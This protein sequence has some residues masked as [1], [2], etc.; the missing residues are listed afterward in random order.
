MEELT[1][2]REWSFLLKPSKMFWWL[3]VRLTFFLVTVTCKYSIKMRKIVPQKSKQEKK[4]QTGEQNPNRRKSAWG[5]SAGKKCKKTKTRQGEMT[6][7]E[8]VQSHKFNRPY[9]YSWY[10]N[11]TCLW[12]RL[13]QGNIIKKRWM[14]FA[15]QKTSFTG[16]SCKLVPVLFWEYKL[17]WE[18]AY[19]DLFCNCAK[20]E[21]FLKKG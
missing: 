14:P 2:I 5:I 20:T 11:G 9:S 13:I 4:I 15:F 6:Q 16:V 7:S 18:C 8:D 19:K 3:S 12:Q 21:V 1:V 17:S 10:W